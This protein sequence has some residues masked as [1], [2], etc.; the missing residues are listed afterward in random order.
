MSEAALPVEEVKGQSEDC[1]KD[2]TDDHAPPQLEH[3]F[4]SAVRVVPW[5]KEFA[6][7]HSQNH[8]SR[9]CG[10]KMNFLSCSVNL[11]G[12]LARV[13]P[14]HRVEVL[15]QV[16]AQGPVTAKAIKEVATEFSQPAKQA[17]A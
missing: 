2:S 1:A 6:E 16:A 5:K 3:F 12:N 14:E 10:Q 15:E 4:A 8:R 7:V 17:Q 13:E 9:W 11:T